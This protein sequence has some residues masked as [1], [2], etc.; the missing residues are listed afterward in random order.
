MLAQNAFQ[1][2]ARRWTA[3][4]PYNVLHL[5]QVKGRVEP[6]QWRDAVATAISPLGFKP[7][8]AIVTTY[9]DLTQGITVELNKPFEAADQPL[10]FFIIQVRPDD[11]YFG[12]TFDHWIADSHSIRL[13]MQRIFSNYKGNGATPELLALRPTTFSFAEL[14]G[15]AN[16][17]AGLYECVRNYVRHRRARPLAIREPLDFSVGF[18]YRQLPNGLIDRIRQFGARRNATVNDVFIAAAAMAFGRRA[19]FDATNK[20]PRDLGA[21]SVAVDLRPL[22]RKSIDDR[23]GFFLGYFNV[24][25]RDLGTAGF[26]DIVK[27]IAAETRAAKSGKRALHLFHV[28]K[29]A[30]FCWD[31]YRQPRRRALMFHRAMPALGGISNVNLSASWIEGDPSILDY[32]RVAPA[33]PILPATFALTTIR[34]RLSLGVTYRNAVISSKQASVIISDFVERLGALP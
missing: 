30:N 32:I 20:N 8:A 16:L 3:L 13:L 1:G 29:F 10:R 18:Q 7:P 15:R 14:F 26:D 31:R 11:Y 5:L 24:L 33:G 9:Q 6:D 19:G 4:G 28:F 23:F 21:I 25:V 34:D 27:Q 17:P 2:L 12:V 22:A